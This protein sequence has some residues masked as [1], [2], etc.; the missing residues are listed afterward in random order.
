[1]LNTDAIS[2]RID[3]IEVYRIIQDNLGD[4]GE[5]VKQVKIFMEEYE[6]R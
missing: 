4:F 3:K 1:V 6:K 5:F 2:V